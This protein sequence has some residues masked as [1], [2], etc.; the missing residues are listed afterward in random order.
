LLPG[1]ASSRELPVQEVIGLP[2][3]SEKELRN[4]EKA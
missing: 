2:M 3:L 4:A 1:N